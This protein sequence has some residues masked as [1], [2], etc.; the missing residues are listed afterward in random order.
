MRHLPSC[1]RSFRTPAVIAVAALLI[2]CTWLTLANTGVFAAGSRFANLNGHNYQTWSR[3]TFSYITA[4]SDGGYMVFE[5]VTPDKDYRVE[6]Y[7]SGLQLKSTLSVPA[8][9]DIFGAF[10]EDRNG[11]Y[12][13]S[14]QKNP[15]ES[16]TLECYR[17]TKYDKSWNRI[18]ACGLSNC[19]TVSPFEAG[20]A[21]IASS[22]NFLVVRTCHTMYSVGGL[23]HQANL[24]FTVDTSTMSI[25]NSR[26]KVSNVTTGYCSHSFNQFVRIYDDY[27]YT[28]DHGDASPRAVVLCKYKTA[29][30][31]GELASRVDY[32]TPFTFG[33]TDGDNKTGASIGGFEVS[34]TSLIAA[35]NSI[36]QSNASSSSTR[37]IFVTTVNKESGSTGTRWLTSDPEGSDSYSTPFLVKI[38]D[39]SFAVIWSRGYNVYYA[40]IDGSGNIQGTVKSAAGM[41]SDCQPVVSGDRIIWYTYDGNNVNFFAINISDKS[42]SQLNPISLY[43]TDIAYIPVQVYTGSE[44]RPSFSIKYAGETLKEGQDYTATYSDNVNYGTATVT[45]TGIGRFNGTRKTYFDIS[46]ADLSTV[47]AEPISDM[48]FTVPPVVPDVELTYGGRSL[49]NGT[50]YR[51]DSINNASAGD[52]TLVLTGKGNFTG[53][54]E[55]PY[56]IIPA[57][58]NDMTFSEIADVTYTGSAVTPYFRVKN[59]TAQL[60][61]NE[62]YTVSYSDNINIGTAKITLTGKGNYTGTKTLTF[63]IVPLSANSFTITSVS[64]VTYTG[65]AITPAVTVRYGSKTLTEGTD[66]TV[67]YKDNVNIGTATIIVTGK[68]IYSGTKEKTFN[69]NPISILYASVTAPQAQTYTGYALTPPVQVKYDGQDL[70]LNKDYTLQYSDNTAVGYGRITITGIGIFSG[71]KT[72]S[73]RIKGIPISSCTFTYTDSY[74]YTGSAIEPVITV[75]YGGKTLVK[76]TDYTVT[77]GS[78]INI[79]S[80]Y[81][82]ITGINN[83]ANTT[84]KYFSITGRSLTEL[85]VSAIPDQAYTGSRVTPSVTIKDGTKTLVPDTDYIM[86]YGNN[87][88]AGNNA[89]VDI[90]GQGKYTGSTTVYFTILPADISKATVSSIPDQIYTGTVR[91]P[92]ITVK[93]N[94]NT[95]DEMIDYSV[96]YYNNVGIGTAEVILTGRGSF[97]GTKRVPFKIV[98]PSS[99]EPSGEL[100]YTW[101]QE[102]KKWYLYDNYGRKA[103]GFVTVSGTTYYMNGSGVMMTGWQQIGGAWYY[104]A[105]SGAMKTGW[106]KISKVWYYF[107]NNG[108]MASGLTVIDGTRYFFKSSG[109]MATGWQQ[110]GSDWYYFASSG[111]CKTGWQQ[112]SK[113]WYYFDNAGRMTTG[114]KMIDGKGYFFKDGGAMVSKKWIE[115]D[116][117]WYWF[118]S[119]GSMAVSETVKIG[120]KEYRFDTKGV[121]LNP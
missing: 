113:V 109:A 33:G 34:G 117:S 99:P 2:A 54:L 98:S 80:G 78:N 96:D 60:S 64:G 61:A 119:D 77:Y 52:K 65:S 97:T 41:L 74:M 79:G 45:I 86:Y 66:Y 75:K 82:A 26:S 6:Y 37:N 3:S 81:A 16:D 105:S 25:T 104:F 100:T 29:I 19:N 39:N 38:N 87:I 10:Y 46:R 40:F 24:T 50:D 111:A 12:V 71:T 20:S 92:S 91:R 7:D 5:G 56:R 62:D 53:T 107:G 28:A 1:K 23:N 43:R 49:V 42:F 73:F 95:L 115:Q 89:Y 22:G 18:G 72:A 32:Y 103:T 116:G 58:I 44:I 4:T 15:D 101:K 51:V 76:D 21:S 59:G 84:Y 94:S 90:M 93:F 14:G 8:E 69:I 17:L 102:S 27:I 36:D 108:K 30:T 11:Y 48:T 68:G 70:I 120:G 55:L 67:S 83:Y 63:N 35:G 47:N 57:D 118:K 88:S 31:G 121:C 85:T 106:Q 9:L 110:I 13:L 114:L 112:I